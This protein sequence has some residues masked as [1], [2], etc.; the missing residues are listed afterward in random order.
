[1]AIRNGQ[2]WGSDKLTPNDLVIVAA[3]A[4]LSQAISEGRRDFTLVGGDMW[5]T[6][7]AKTERPIPGELAKCL[8]IDVINVR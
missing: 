7:G 6:I 5:R 1:M 2:E 8:P 3:D 4:D